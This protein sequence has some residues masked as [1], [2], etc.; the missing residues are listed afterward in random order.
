M[1]TARRITYKSCRRVQLLIPTHKIMQ[2]CCWARTTDYAQSSQY[3][4]DQGCMSMPMC[5]L[6]MPCA[7]TSE[8][9]ALLTLLIVERASGRCT[10]TATS[11][12]VV[13]N[14]ALYTCKSN[15]YTETYCTF[16]SDLPAAVSRGADP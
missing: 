16:D 7:A 4:Q 2:A 5:K 6:Q 9:I 3:C 8:R 10:L 1:T 13:L 12:P 15:H 14:L 11:S